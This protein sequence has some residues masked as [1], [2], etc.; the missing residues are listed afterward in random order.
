VNLSDPRFQ[1]VDEARKWL[2]AQRWPQGM[3]CPHCGNFDQTKIKTLRGKSHRSGLHSCAECG[4]QFTVTVGTPLQRSKIPLNKWVLAIHLMSE[5]E[6]GISTRQLQR[7]LN[8]AYQSAWSVR[9]RI[10]AAMAKT[11]DESQGARVMAVKAKGK[12]D[13]EPPVGSS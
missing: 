5:S 3:R 6:K 4:E 12:A 2:E 9:Y 13:Q 10:R 7:L 11:Q 8:V 1:D